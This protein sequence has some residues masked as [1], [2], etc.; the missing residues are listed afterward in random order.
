ML[1]KFLIICILASSGLAHACVGLIELP[2]QH[3]AGS[4]TVFYPCLGPSKIEKRT[5][6]DLDVAIDAEP[7][8]GNGRLIVISHGS[9]ASP[10]VYFDLAHSMVEAGFIVALP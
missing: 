8:R 1:K 9:P 5:T 6:F 4:V 10:W 2:P 3:D 7:V